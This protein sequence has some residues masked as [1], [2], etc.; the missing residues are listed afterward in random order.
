MRHHSS[1]VSHMVLNGG[2]EWYP[3]RSQQ[4]GIVLFSYLSR[5]CGSCLS[6]LHQHV[7]ELLILM[8][9]DTLHILDQL[10]RIG[11]HICVESM[12]IG[13]GATCILR[14][15][16]VHRG[17]IMLSFP[18]SARMSVLDRNGL[19]LRM[20]CTMVRILSSMSVMWLPWDKKCMS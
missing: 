10:W 9:I 1:V 5:P 11:D 14:R 16:T 12:G 4:L 20:W 8:L 15:R 18:S 7:I 3:L 2:Q 6:L 17:K 13:C 19:P